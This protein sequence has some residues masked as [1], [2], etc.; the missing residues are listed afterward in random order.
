MANINCFFRV[1]PCVPEK[2]ASFNNNYSIRNK[3]PCRAIP[4]KYSVLNVIIQRNLV[5]ESCTETSS[6]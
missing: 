2:N 4:I 5:T 1:I 6:I 3:F